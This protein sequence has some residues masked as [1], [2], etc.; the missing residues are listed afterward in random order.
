[1]FL[2]VIYEAIR[3]FREK[4]RATKPETTVSALP[5]RARAVCRKWAAG[6]LLRTRR[7]GAS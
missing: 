5:A 4:N 7:C 2:K 6:D 3:V 1:M